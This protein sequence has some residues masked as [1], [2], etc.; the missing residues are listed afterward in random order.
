MMEWL[1]WK[2][3]RVNRLVFITA[4]V[5]LVAPHVLAA[6]LLWSGVAQGIGTFVGSA[7][8]SMALLQVTLAFMGGNA[9]AGERIDRSAEFFA[10]MPVS[11]GRSLASRLLVTLALVGLIWLPNLVFGPG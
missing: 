7:V 2:D 3:C 1:V 6:I 5:L 9:I 4:L 8:Y 11:R 10:C